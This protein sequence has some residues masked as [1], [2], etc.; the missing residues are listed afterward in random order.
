[1][2]C[3]G[4]IRLTLGNLAIEGDLHVDGRSADKLD[5]RRV[6]RK[7]HSVVIDSCSIPPQSRSSVRRKVERSLRGQNRNLWRNC[8]SE[9]FD[10]GIVAKFDIATLKSGAGA[11]ERFG[12]VRRNC[13]ERL[14]HQRNFKLPPNNCVERK[15]TCGAATRCR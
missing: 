1:M 5:A 12:T 6:L 15:K 13:V 9:Y 11:L 2:N 8:G 4:L 7:E 14:G 10:E 3:G